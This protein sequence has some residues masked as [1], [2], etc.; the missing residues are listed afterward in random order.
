MFCLTIPNKHLCFS[1]YTNSVSIFQCMHFVLKPRKH[2]C[3]KH[4]LCCLYYA[5]F[6]WWCRQKRA[7]QRHVYA[8]VYVSQ[9]WTC[10]LKAVALALRAISTKSHRALNRA[11][12]DPLFSQKPVILLTNYSVIMEAGWFIHHKYSKKS[13]LIFPQVTFWLL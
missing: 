1:L 6:K 7:G 4:R 10:R 11:L 9:A 5:V 8:S 2:T 13:L 3:C 12:R